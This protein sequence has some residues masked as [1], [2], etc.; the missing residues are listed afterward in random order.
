[1]D[2]PRIVVDPD[3]PEDVRSLLTE[4]EN[5]EG[6]PYSLQSLRP[7]SEGEDQRLPLVSGK[8][9]ATVAGGVALDALLTVAIGWEPSGF[10]V[11]LI[12]PM[13]VGAGMVL[14]GLT[15]RYWRD[16]NLTLRQAHG[17]YVLAADL[18]EESRML[19]ARTHWAITTVLCSQVRADG[20]LDHIRNEVVL[21]RMEWEIAWSLR[22]ISKL[23]CRYPELRQG[24]VADAGRTLAA[25]MTALRQRI[26]ALEK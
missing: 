18:D 4:W 9:M 3:L 8:T 5:G 16:Q 25:T 13:L 6:K 15:P 2:A 26:A 20:T 17:R 14:W 7:L 11:L 10:L 22:G 12:L 19:L 21:P 1:M 23:R 24:T